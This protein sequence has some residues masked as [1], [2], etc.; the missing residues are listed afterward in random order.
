MQS[1]IRAIVAIASLAI[2]CAA[3]LIAGPQPA[4]VAAAAGGTRPF[5]EP[6]VFNAGGPKL[7]RAPAPGGLATPAPACTPP[8]QRVVGRN[9]F[10]TL[11]IA[12]TKPPATIYNPATGKDDPVRLRVYGDCISSPTISA[13]PGQSLHIAVANALP[14]N[15]PSCTMGDLSIGCYNVTN[16][17]SHGLHVSP[18]GISDNVLR[19]MQP[20]ASP[21]PVRIDI[22]PDHPAG[23]FWYHAHQHGSTAVQ[24]T[25]GMAGVLIVNGKR[26]F[27]SANA[28]ID[29]ILH[30]PNHVAFPQKLMLFE[31]ISYGC[32]TDDTYTTLIK[33]SANGR[34]I[35][36]D[37]AGSTGSNATRGVVENFAAQVGN[38][39]L[40]GQSG[41]F[42]TINGVVQPTLTAIAGRLERWR[43][44]HGGI[45]DTIEVRIVKASSST[46]AGNLSNLRGGPGQ[47]Q[48]ALDI[49]CPDSG[50]IPQYEIAVDG[51][52]RRRIEEIR[53]GAPGNPGVD[54]LQPGYRSDVLIVFPSAG[55]YC[56]IDDNVKAIQATVARRGGGTPRTRRLLAIVDVRGTS[57]VTPSLSYVGRQLAAA[58]REL[59][60]SVLTALVRGDI[61]PW[62]P[63]PR[64]LPEPG[65]SPQP[66]PN[67]FPSPGPVPQT[68][69]TKCVA[70]S[71]NPPNF[72]PM[73]I[74]ARPYEHDVMNYRGTVG[75][76]DEYRIV[77]DFDHVFH[78]HVNP[79]QIVDVRGPDPVSKQL[80]SIY[81]AS[82]KCLPWAD[83]QYCGQK[84]I[85]RDTL[86]V[87]QGYEL[88]VRTA[89]EVYDGKFVLHCHIL[90]HEDLGMMA[91][92]ELVKPATAYGAPPRAHRMRH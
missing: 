32:F 19:S 52:T 13:D 21:Y 78:I 90:D 57:V 35:C 27:P 82:G 79:F 42:T 87:K 53:R 4:Q 68:R 64:D 85:Y 22:P 29:T 24:V 84:G 26:K 30:D 31:Q 44:V 59:P 67:P 56:V 66:C 23:T 49:A 72:N 7:L 50:D 38:P 33:E 11:G 45:R 86:I 89:Y 51:L 41:R 70:F 81:D 18:S 74:N 65:G 16:F 9:V 40:W 8:S 12:Y 55:T 80:T 3:V 37:N 73:V 2:F 46:T 62:S 25:S 28:D 48:P 14:T 77:T 58:N 60:Q 76:I 6:P 83:K 43:L 36:P 47:Q 54:V 63:H 39:R 91:N 75:Q 1:S 10:L 61:R 88:V 17:H 69:N 34:W 5:V 20:T 92:V 15:R 71:V